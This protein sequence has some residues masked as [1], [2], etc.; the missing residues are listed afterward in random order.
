[1]DAVWRCLK[2]P[3]IQLAIKKSWY[4]SIGPFFATKVV[5]IVGLYIDPTDKVIVI[6]VDEKPDDTSA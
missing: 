6:A 4:I 3:G 2:K 5:D 1:M